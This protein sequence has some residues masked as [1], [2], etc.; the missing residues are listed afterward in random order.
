MAAARALDVEGV[1]VVA[2]GMVLG[3]IERFE[4]VVGRLDLRP[5]DH[6]KSDREEDAQQFVERLPDQVPRPDG[7]LDAR[8]RKVL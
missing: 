6:A 2:R 8:K 3:D 5:F 1:H 7:A 4:I